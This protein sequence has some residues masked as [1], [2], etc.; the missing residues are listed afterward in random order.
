VNEDEVQPEDSPQTN[1]IALRLWPVLI[2]LLLQGVALVLTVTPT[3][4]NASRFGI[5]VLGPAICFLL[6]AC[7]LMFFSRLRWRDRFSLFLGI[8]LA[9]LLATQLID[10]TMGV[11]LWIYGI[12]LAMTTTAACLWFG[13]R[14]RPTQR[15]A[16]VVA[17]VACGWSL[18]LLGRLEGFDGTYWPEL[19]WRWSQHNEL[20]LARES[21]PSSVA[22]DQLAADLVITDRDWT[23]FRGTMRDGRVRQTRIATTWNETTP[24]ELWRIPVGPAWSSF[25]AVGDDL[26]TQEQRGENEVVVCYDAKTGAE[27]W[28]HAD[29]TRF[30]EVVSG[31]GPRATPTYSDGQLFTFGARAMLNCLDARSGEL[32]WQRDL[33]A[34]LG[35]K[36]PIWG[37]SASPLAVDGLVMVYVGGTQGLIACEKSTG[38][39]RW[40][41]AGSGMNYSSAQL[42][43]LLGK[44][45]V[46]LAS[47]D[48]LVALEP[49]TGIVA[50]EYEHS[51]KRGMAIV[52]PQQIGESSVIVPFGDGGGLARIDVELVDNTWQ[53]SE[54]WTTRSLKPSFNDFVFHAGHIYGF[55]QHIFTCI[56]AETGQRRWKRGR[57][58]FGQVILFV[59]QGLL[60]ITSETGEV[61]L[62]EANSK[63][64]VEVA[65]LKAVTGKTWNHP[66]MSH[67]RLV[68]RNS[69]EAVC[70]DFSPEP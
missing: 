43:K 41:V 25:S 64:H 8:I 30:S 60:L 5:M 18:F 34:E 68:I 10:N 37:F 36:L 50:F 27:K 51:G 45:F 67:N 38:K 33:M 66:T 17:L 35:A 47:T 32:Q 12:P 63:K 2:I 24:R 13:R 28:R 46:L 54:R 16:V 23:E 4:D 59:E 44:Q 22:D 56:D 62:L 57:Y 21:S 1:R 9:G 52:Q 14:W 20:A 7:W 29:R 6:F 70:Y 65:R 3:I 55:D 15:T 39:T 11:A 42:V 40:Q 58:G 19:R 53:V 61:V 49:Q 26:F 31:P 69:S 48:K